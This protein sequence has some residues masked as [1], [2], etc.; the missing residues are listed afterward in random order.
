M[1]VKHF[2]VAQSLLEYRNRAPL[3]FFM[4]KYFVS[5]NL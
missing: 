1:L 4:S 3:G 2:P 5:G